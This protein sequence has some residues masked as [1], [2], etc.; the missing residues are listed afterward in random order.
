IAVIENLDGFNWGYDPLHFNAPE[1]SYAT[2]PEGFTRIKEMRAMNMALHN[3]GLRVVMDV[4][5]PHTPVSG[6]GDAN[7]IFDKIVPGYYYR[8]N[9]V[10]GEAEGGTGA[11]SDTAGE[12]RMVGKFIKDSIVQ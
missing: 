2:D 3:L 1:G 9:P 5:Y 7:S 8:S 6:I 10:T 12:H 4:V 11:G